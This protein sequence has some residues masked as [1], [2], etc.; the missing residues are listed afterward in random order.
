MEEKIHDLV[1]G[2]AGYTTGFSASLLQVFCAV[3]HPGIDIVCCV[4]AAVVLY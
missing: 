1:E 4:S 2:M 3:S